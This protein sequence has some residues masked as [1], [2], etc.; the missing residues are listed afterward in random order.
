MAL[1]PI[2][3]RLWFSSQPSTSDIRPVAKARRLSALHNRG[4]DHRPR[5]PIRRERQLCPRLHDFVVFLR[6][7]GPLSERARRFV[8]LFPG[9]GVPSRADKRHPLAVMRT[10]WLKNETNLYQS[11]KRRRRQTNLVGIPPCTRRAG[12]TIWWSP[13]CFMSGLKENPDVR[14]YVSKSSTGLWSMAHRPLKRTGKMAASLSSGGITTP[15]RSK[16]WKSLVVASD[17][18]GPPLE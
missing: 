1:I 13:Q 4:G 8:G 10:P 3:G 7:E 16:I 12:T 18:R 11:A 17:T 14:T 2:P 5:I 9:Q 15:F 6:S